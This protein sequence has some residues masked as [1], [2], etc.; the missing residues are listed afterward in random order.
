MSPAAESLKKTTEATTSIH[1]LGMI[2]V[3]LVEPRICIKTMADPD[4]Y[5]LSVRIHLAAGGSV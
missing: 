3:E 4:P 2:R 1:V 5:L